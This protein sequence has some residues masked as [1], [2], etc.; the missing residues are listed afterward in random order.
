[1]AETMTILSVVSFLLAGVLGTM[2]IVFWLQFDIPEIMGDLGKKAA[3]RSARRGSGRDVPDPTE[4]LE[5][6]L[7]IHTS[8][9]IQKEEEEA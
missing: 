4:R 5:D 2:A 7:I 9:V 8:D 1:M 6:I 3:K